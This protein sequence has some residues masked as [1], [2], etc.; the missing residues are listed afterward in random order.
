MSLTENV[1][2]KRCYLAFDYDTELTSTAESERIPTGIRKN[3]YATVTM[4]CFPV[5][6]HVPTDCPS[7]WRLAHG[8]RAEKATDEDG[9][10]P[11]KEKDTT[12]KGLK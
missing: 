6:R 11:I 10:L 8:W 3:L 12:M 7:T 9:F 5:T 1:K 2:Q 4:P